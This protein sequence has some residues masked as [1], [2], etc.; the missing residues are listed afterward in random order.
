MRQTAQ[1][2]HGCDTCTLAH[3]L[4]G[5]LQLLCAS[6]YCADCFFFFFSSNCCIITLVLKE[7]VFE[8]KKG[9]HECNIV[10]LCWRR[11]VIVVSI[12]L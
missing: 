11:C 3:L 10:R 2:T 12:S 6:L 1:N 7:A 4:Y 8:S 5:I 9:G